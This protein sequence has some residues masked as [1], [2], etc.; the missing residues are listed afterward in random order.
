[1]APVFVLGIMVLAAFCGL[2][3]VRGHDRLEPAEWWPIGCYLLSP[4]A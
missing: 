1:M 3:H 4:C 2:R